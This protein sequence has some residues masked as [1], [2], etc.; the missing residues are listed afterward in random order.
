M[1]NSKTKVWLFRLRGLIIK[2]YKKLDED[3]LAYC[4]YKQVGNKLV[5]TYYEPDPNIPVSEIKAHINL[6]FDDTR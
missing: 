6:D 1:R 4:G 3:I 2:T 5:P